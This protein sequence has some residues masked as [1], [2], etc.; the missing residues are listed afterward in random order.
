[1]QKFKCVVIIGVVLIVP[2]SV[3]LISI[4]SYFDV[5]DFT[6]AIIRIRK[7]FD[8]TAGR[9]PVVPFYHISLLLLLLFAEKLRL[10][11]SV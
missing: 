8:Q 1:V 5:C 9:L 3:L 7:R 6:L 10:V 2:Y 4:V 11:V